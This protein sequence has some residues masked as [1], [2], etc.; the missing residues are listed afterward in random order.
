M[1]DTDRPGEEQE[2][3][4]TTLECLLTIQALD[5]KSALD[6]AS[7]LVAEAL[8]AE[9]ADAFL[10]DPASSTLVAVGTSTTPL[11]RRQKQL[12]LGRLPLANGGQAVTVFQTGASY[13][14]GQAADDPNVPPGITRSLGVHSLIDVA[15]DVQGVR[16]GVFEVSSTRPDAF[17]FADLRFSE[18]VARWIGLMVHRAELVEQVTQ[19]AAEQAR[20]VAADELIRVLAHDLR[21]P[22]VPALGYLT[23]LHKDAL[24]AERPQAM[25][26][27]EQ[28]QLAL[29]RL[30]HMISAILDASRLEQG[31]F[32]LNSAACRSG[33]PYPADRGDAPAAREVHH[34]A[35]CRRSCGRG[36]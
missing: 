32:A 27:A 2:R 15:L 20:R 23:M 31:L 33:G 14:T 18:A 1:R 13:H 34:G 26:Y 28:G 11:G 21:G 22:L 6:Q 17:S 5:M 25:H 24:R 29:K 16:R 35:G 7:T 10:H 12:G 8:G 19:A 30:Q 9:K 3:L 36:G 4:L